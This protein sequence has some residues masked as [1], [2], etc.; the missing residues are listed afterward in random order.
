MKSPVFGG[1]FGCH[2][3]YIMSA[4]LVAF[5]VVDSSH[6]GFA[7]TGHL[8]SHVGPHGG[9]HGFNP[10]SILDPETMLPVG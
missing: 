4:I 2:T 6:I 7:V 5:L 9:H 10:S 3:V 1:H 8:G